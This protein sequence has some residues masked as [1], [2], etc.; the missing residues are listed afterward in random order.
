MGWPMVAREV[1]DEVVPSLYARALESK[2]A[3]SDGLAAAHNNLGNAYLLSGDSARATAQYGQAVELSDGL[4]AAHFNLSRALSFGGVEAL[5]KVQA[6]QQRALVLDRASIDAFTEGSPQVN[7]RANRFVLDVPLPEASLSS[8]DASEGALSSAVGD[9][10]RALFAAPLPADLALAWPLLAGLAFL[11]LH[12]G[13]ARLRP[14]ATCLRC[15]REVCKRCD[16]DARPAEGLCAQCVNVF[17]RRTNVDASERTRKEIGVAQY[18]RRRTL[19]VRGLGLLS[20]AGHVALGHPLRGLLFLALSGTLLASV[21]LWRGIAPSPVAVR[22]TVSFLRVGLT[23]AFFLAVNA[24]CFRD[25]L[26]L[27]RE[28]GG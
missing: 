9:E 5:D 15:G 8:L 4:A 28:E 19:V 25:L 14:S 3:S 16:G 23:A 2:G 6:E 13:R 11:G 20:G 27:Q 1:A 7:R 24:I 21:L 12:F 22:G 26:A 17:V 10:A 18:R